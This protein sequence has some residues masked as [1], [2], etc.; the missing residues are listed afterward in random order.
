M[1]TTGKWS[2]TG[3]NIFAADQLDAIR[4]HLQD[5]GFIVVLWWHYY[6]SQAPTRLTFDSYDEWLS[7][8]KA[9]PRQGDAIDVWPFP[10][11]PKARIAYG[12]IPNKEGEVPE[13]G[14]Y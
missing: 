10:S 8:L 1:S 13:G 5:V 11:D 6:G 12:K 7:F 9:A 3:A 2:T 14:A 4:H